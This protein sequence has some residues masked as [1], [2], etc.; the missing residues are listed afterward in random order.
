MKWVVLCSVVVLAWGGP[1]LC[2]QEHPQSALRSSG[3][4]WQDMTA[5]DLPEREAL[6]T[7]GGA[8]VYLTYLTLG[9]VYDNVAAGTYDRT[10]AEKLV[11]S[12]RSLAETSVRRLQEVADEGGDD[13]VLASIRGLYKAL[14]HEADALLAYIRSGSEKDRKTFQEER[15]KVW[16]RIADALG[17]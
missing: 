1:R 10:T 17:L 8:N 6:G 7:L 16:R 12:V 9:A 4:V 2:A 11:L 15:T 14:R 3:M 13:D 5:E